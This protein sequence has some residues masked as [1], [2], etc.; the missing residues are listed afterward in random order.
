MEPLHVDGQSIKF[1]DRKMWKRDSFDA[2]L[3]FEGKIDFTG[4][5]Y[6]VASASIAEQREVNRSHSARRKCPIEVEYPKKRRIL[7]RP[8]RFKTYFSDRKP[9]S[10]PRFSI[11]R[12][13]KRV[14]WIFSENGWISARLMRSS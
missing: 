14:S 7:K 5:V 12:C 10:I 6:A 4:K 3:G 11:P 1:V 9:L 8:K 13:S 2:K